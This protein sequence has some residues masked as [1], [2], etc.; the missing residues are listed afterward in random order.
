MNKALLP[1]NF[2]NFIKPAL[3]A[4]LSLQDFIDISA[5]PLRK[6]IRI[7]T[8]KTDVKTFVEKAQQKGWQLETIPWCETGFWITRPEAEEN[9][10]G[11]GNT[12]EHL[13][14]QFYIQEASSML[15][16]QALMLQNTRP[17][18]CLDVAAAP[19]S[20]TTQIAALMKNN[21]ILIANEFSSSRAKGLFGN[22]QRCAVS[23]TALTHLDGRMFIHLPET[24][25]AILLD[26]PCSGEGTVRK[27]PDAMKNWSEQSVHD[28]AKVQKDLI[29]AAFHALKPNGTLIYSTCTLNP[30]ENQQV[31]QWLASTH[32]EAVEFEPLADLFP[33]AENCITEAGFLHVWPQIYN[34]E[35]FFVARIR[36]TQS[37][38]HQLDNPFSRLGKFP[39]THVSKK[40]GAQF[41]EYLHQQFG[42]QDFD[43]SS[44]YQRNQA[45]WYFPPQI[46]KL[47]GKVKFARVGVKLAELAKHGFKLDH[48]LA[49][50][51]AHL[52]TRQKV[53]VNKLQAQNYLRGQD[54]DFDCSELQKGE[55]L[56]TTDDQ[57]LGFAKKLP[58]RLKNQ[59]PRELVRDNVS[60]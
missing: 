20:K 34:S 28:I 8:L 17:E 6:S 33:G 57:A 38:S 30:I 14:G 1:E 3:P 29:E 45:I 9:R 19:G 58:D 7:N 50:N 24:F 40:L 53:N 46:E 51:F 2:I 44:C 16:P 39:Y 26:A 18:I 10:I 35:G 5:Q 23:N 13:T 31:C 36:K 25:D 47:I 27:D 32:P 52:F 42:I 59:L 49:V 55:V 22:I 11:L 43:L 56:I 60:F 41:V 37:V 48:S 4:H 15:P 21:G 12:L 54:I